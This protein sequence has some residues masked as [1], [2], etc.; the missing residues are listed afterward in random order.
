M[1]RKRRVLFGTLQNLGE[2]LRVARAPPRQARVDRRSNS[3]LE[4]KSPPN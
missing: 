1:Q 2:G 4:T 3:P